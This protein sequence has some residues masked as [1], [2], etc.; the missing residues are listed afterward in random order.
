LP[1]CFVIHFSFQPITVIIDA[2]GVIAYAGWLAAAAD[3]ITASARH[4][5]TRCRYCLMPGWLFYITLKTRLSRWRLPPFMS[6]T[7]VIIIDHH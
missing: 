3:A 1:P 4:A 2:S 6:V 5:A 7:T